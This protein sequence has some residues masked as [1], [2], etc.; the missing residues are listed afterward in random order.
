MRTLRQAFDALYAEHGFR[1]VDYKVDSDASEPRLCLNFSER[2]ATGQADHAKFLSLDGK[3]PQSVSA[4]GQQV[5]IDGLAHGKRYEVQVRAGLPSAEGELLAK[6]S[7]IAVYVRDRAASVRFTGRN[8]VLPSRGQ[9]GIPVVTV[10][11]DKVAVEILRI[12]DRGLVGAVGGE[13]FL[14]QMQSYEVEALRE[15]SGQRVWQGELAVTSRL[16]EDVTTALPVSDAVPKLE[17]GVYLI[18]AR[19]GKAE[20]EERSTATQW[21]I[22]SDLGLSALSGD[23]GLH[24][25]VRS[26]ATA[27]PVPGIAGAPHRAQQRGPGHREDR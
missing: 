26:L 22:V 11:T 17:P 8:Y 12:G 16:N 4:E 20:G 19:A 1:I 7:E 3:D 2:V 9:V 27:A 23:D 6:A 24:A 14:K 13:S 25:F 21:F 18:S 5:C 10:N 15:R